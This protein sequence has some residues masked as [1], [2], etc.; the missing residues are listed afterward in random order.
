MIDWKETA[1]D[2]E[3]QLRGVVDMCEELGFEVRLEE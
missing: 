2:G 3:T 1:V